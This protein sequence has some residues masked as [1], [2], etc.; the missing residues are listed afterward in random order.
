MSACN[1]KSGVSFL[2]RHRCK[3]QERSAP[4]N[5]GHASWYFCDIHAMPETDSTAWCIL[6]LVTIPLSHRPHPL[7]TSSSVVRC[8]SRTWPILNLLC[9]LCRPRTLRSSCLT[10][11]RTWDYRYAPP[12]SAE[13]FPLSCFLKYCCSLEVPY[14]DGLASRLILLRCHE[15]W[16]LSL[17]DL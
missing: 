6:P 15:I 13:G 12:N 3:D 2:K 10:P 11:L 5:V 8:H 16:K 17:G 9:N 7:F 1:F 14:V 4:W